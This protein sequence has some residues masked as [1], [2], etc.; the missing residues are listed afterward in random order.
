[1][2]NQL[3]TDISNQNNNLSSTPN[4]YKM[5]VVSGIPIFPGQTIHFDLQ[6]D[7]SMLALERAYDV[8]ENVFLVLQKHSKTQKPAPKD[9]YRVGVV[10]KIQQMLHLP[11]DTVRVLV[12]AI[13]RMEIDTYVSINP[14]FEVS[15]IDIKEPEED[16]IAISAIKGAVH[17]QVDVLSKLESKIPKDAINLMLG[18]DDEKIIATAG[19]FIFINDSQRQQ[20]L[21]IGRASCRERV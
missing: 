4:S 14:Y 11:N 17:K 5:V 18:D 3:F 10:A 8:K 15:L 16:P 1:M 21:E 20:L 13:N 6:K 12:T 7:K 9:L 2:A 19:T